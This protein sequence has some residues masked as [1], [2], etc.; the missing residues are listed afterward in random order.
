MKLLFINGSH[1][2]SRGFTGVCIDKLIEGAVSS[3][4]ECEKINL[5]EKRITECIACAKCLDPNH[6]Q[7]CIYH[8]S[9]D[10]ASIFDE[11]KSADIILYATPVY[12]MAISGLLKKFFDRFYS[13]GNPH[14]LKLTKSGLLF[15]HTVREILSKPFAVLVCGDNSEDL[16]Y[17]N[18]IQY[19]KVYSEF[20][21]AKQVGLLIRRSAFMFQQTPMDSG[22]EDAI[23]DIYASLNNAG[24]EL[25]AHGKISP[26][27]Q[28]HVGKNIMPMPPIFKLMKNFRFVKRMV[29]QYASQEKS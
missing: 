22:L 20:L 29:I 15:H 17:S 5:S 28:R 2:G 27:T 6:Y 18:I 24:K 25:V 16:T 3:G 12:V 19:F 7:R 10:V 21:E 13:I 23:N 26:K 9:D 14:L 11:M 8:D 1:R 4:A